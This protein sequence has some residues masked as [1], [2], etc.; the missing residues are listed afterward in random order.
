MTGLQKIKSYCLNDERII[1]RRNQNYSHARVDMPIGR[2][3]WQT[4]RTEIYKSWILYNMRVDK[5][6]I[7]FDF[8]PIQIIL[9]T[10]SP[11]EGKHWKTHNHIIYDL[12]YIRIASRQQQSFRSSRTRARVCH[13]IVSSVTTLIQKLDSMMIKV[14]TTLEVGLLRYHPSTRRACYE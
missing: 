14:N 2:Q 8:R 3:T 5:T 9:L 7:S 10:Q 1:V 11:I 13:V 6:F 4:L 12:V